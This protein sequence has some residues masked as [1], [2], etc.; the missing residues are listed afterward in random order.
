[1]WAVLYLHET[2]R[3]A[4]ASEEMLT[5]GEPRIGAAHV[6]DDDARAREVSIPSGLP[7]QRRLVNGR[8]GK[9]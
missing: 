6:E 9:R 4:G 1:H 8:I 7:Y 3:V 5:A 2:H